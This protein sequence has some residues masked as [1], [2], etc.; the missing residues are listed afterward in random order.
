MTSEKAPEEVR[1]NIPMKFLY[2]FILSHTEPGMMIY[3]IGLSATVIPAS[4]LATV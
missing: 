2:F 1:K 3:V 4:S